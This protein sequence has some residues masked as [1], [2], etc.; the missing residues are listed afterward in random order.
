MS[1]QTRVAKAI[2]LSMGLESESANDTTR[3][4]RG[5]RPVRALTVWDHLRVNGQLR[6]LERSQQGYEL[7][8]SSRLAWLE[9]QQRRDKG[10]SPLELR[11]RDRAA[12]GKSRGGRPGRRVRLNGGA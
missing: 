7:Q 2:S 8:P 5:L 12:G 10:L 11:R 9:E 6:E 3:A 4:Q 1:R